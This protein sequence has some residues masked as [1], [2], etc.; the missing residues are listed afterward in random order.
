MGSIAWQESISCHL[1]QATATYHHL[2]L[3]W[4]QGGIASEGPLL[5]AV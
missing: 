5:M 3:A 1:A 4:E 2:L